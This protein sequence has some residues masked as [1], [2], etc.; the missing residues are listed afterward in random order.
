MQALTLGSSDGQPPGEHSGSGEVSL[1]HAV[2]PAGSDTGARSC[3]Q[4]PGSGLRTAASMCVRGCPCWTWASGRGSWGRLTGS[5]RGSR[6]FRQPQWP[7]SELPDGSY[8][9]GHK[10]RLSLKLDPIQSS[11]FT[12]GSRSVSKHENGFSE[13]SVK[14]RDAQTIACV[15]SKPCPRQDRPRVWSA[16]SPRARR[17]PVRQATHA[18]RTCWRAT[19]KA[20][21]RQLQQGR[22]AGRWP[23]WLSAIDPLH[24]K[25]RV[26]GRG[27]TAQ[28]L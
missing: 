22:M 2:P 19:L 5:E 18:C 1:T 12:S 13:S 15:G 16:A 4:G 26:V 27:T 24:P 23:W 3:P 25:S 10:G 14:N 7:W 17:G 9:P 21:L 8:D 28:L 11:E 6:C 20:E